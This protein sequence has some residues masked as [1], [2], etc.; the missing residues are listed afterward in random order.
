MLNSYR[1]LTSCNIELHLMLA[2]KYISNLSFTY[3]MFYSESLISH[4]DFQFHRRLS[5]L[6]MYHYTRLLLI[7]HFNV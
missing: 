7:R 4:V 6:N 5:L 3:N 1:F 2:I